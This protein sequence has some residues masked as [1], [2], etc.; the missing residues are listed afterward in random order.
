M[1]GLDLLV[2]LFFFS[3][4][5]LPFAMCRLRI[6]TRCIDS[7]RDFFT[8]TRVNKKGILKA[9]FGSADKRLLVILG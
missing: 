3:S 4:T 1:L 8:F 2:F 6:Y 7:F 5:A 9:L